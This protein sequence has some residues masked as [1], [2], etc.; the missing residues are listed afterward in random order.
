MNSAPAHRTFPNILIKQSDAE[1]V[2]LGTLET[3]NARTTQKLFLTVLYRP[4]SSKWARPPDEN[5]PIP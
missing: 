1:V 5:L 2:E 4:T 3:S